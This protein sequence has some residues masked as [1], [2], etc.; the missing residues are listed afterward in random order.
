MKQSRLQQT[1]VTLNARQLASERDSHIADIDPRALLVVTLVYLV[2][3]LS[4]PVYD[5]GMIIWFAVY[6]IVTA[7]L[8]HLP[9]ER[10]ARQSLYVAPLLIV[11]GIF[12]PLFD[13]APVLMAGGFAVSGGWVSFV[14]IIIRGLL[15]VQALLLLIYVAGFNRMCEGLNRLKVPR[16]LVTQLLMVYRYIAV[17]LQEAESMQRARTARGYGRG[18]YGPKMWGAFVGQL[19]LRAME[20]SR[21]IHMAMKARGFNGLL[22]V[23]QARRW[24]TADTVYCLSWIPV[25]LLMRFADISALMFH[26][27]NLRPQ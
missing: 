11:I 26:L 20:R 22:P 1:I 7:P 8:A 10:V 19:M 13:K 3:L 5:L 4:V 21:M 23:G 18:S 17:L 16:V 12:N 15:S 25:I 14:S 2:A 24:S 6:P 27:F 9:Y